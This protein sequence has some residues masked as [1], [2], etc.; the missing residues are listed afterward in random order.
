MY[1]LRRHCDCVHT[2]T[3]LRGYHRLLNCGLYWYLQRNSVKL[4]TMLLSFFFLNFISVS[5]TGIHQLLPW[6]RSCGIRHVSIWCR[7]HCVRHL[8]SADCEIYGTWTSLRSHC[9]VS[10]SR[11]FALCYVAMGTNTWSR[12]AYLFDGIGS[13]SWHFFEAIPNKR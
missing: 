11:G 9:C 7:R 5:F 13:W 3:E 8:N 2:G 6:Y 10:W 1:G 4:W 12:L